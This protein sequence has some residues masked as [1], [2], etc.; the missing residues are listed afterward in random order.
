MD[1]SSPSLIS[2]S[3]FSKRLP[4][5]Q[6]LLKVEPNAM[7][8]VAW[9]RYAPRNSAY[10]K[11]NCAL[12]LIDMSLAVKN[13]L[14]FAPVAIFAVQIGC[15]AQGLQN[16][17]FSTKGAVIL[18]PCLDKSGTDLMSGGGSTNNEFCTETYNQLMR[19]GGAKTISWF[20]VNSELEKVV[21]GANKNS[22]PFLSGSSLGK[23]DYTNDMY[24]PELIKAGKL[25]GPKYIIR[26]V[27]LNKESTQEQNMNVRTGFMG[28]GAGV[29]R[30]S[31]KSSNVTV[32]IDV[33]GIQ[34]QDI[35]ASKSFFGDVN[36]TKKTQ[37]GLG[38]ET[39]SFGSA[40]G[41]DAG[42]RAAM[43]DAIYKSIEYISERVD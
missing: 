21:K 43:T 36:T 40:G 7:P 10:A 1:S 24:I 6:R 2:K 38:F 12:R 4:V 34:A 27:V 14:S 41:M 9:A 23:T 11:V 28:F 42:T 3:H 18:M 15:Y 35:V 37:K 8:L 39:S 26:P 32:K 22:N 25:L 29:D 20:K 19:D 30:S 17:N 33:I 13:I 16:V 31:S 5:E